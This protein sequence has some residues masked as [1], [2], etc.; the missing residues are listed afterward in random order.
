MRD[1][2]EELVYERGQGFVGDSSVAPRTVFALLRLCA[3]HAEHGSEPGG[4]ERYSIN[5]TGTDLLALYE[6]N[7]AESQRKV[8]KVKVLLRK[9]LLRN[10]RKENEQPA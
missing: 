3:L 7:S 5:E 9:G 10:A 4:F 1:E 6:T 8:N 2:E